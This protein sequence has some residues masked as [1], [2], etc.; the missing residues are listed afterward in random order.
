MPPR[1]S[2]PVSFFNHPGGSV[3]VGVGAR[4]SSSEPGKVVEQGG[5][6][7]LAQV[8]VPEG[9]GEQEV[10]VGVRGA[11]HGR[12]GDGRTRSNPLSCGFCTRKGSDSV[13]SVI[14]QHPARK[15][16][17]DFLRPFVDF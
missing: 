16:C 6:R 7:L 14:Y 17:L 9:V 13:G 11:R 2:S 12:Q 1:L 3:L 8:V 4:V 10:G 5:R 15:V